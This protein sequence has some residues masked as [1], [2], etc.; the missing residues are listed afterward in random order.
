MHHLHVKTTLSATDAGT[1]AQATNQLEL[2]AVAAGWLLETV[3][4]GITER[5]IKLKSPVTDLEV[6]VVWDSVPTATVGSPDAGVIPSDKLCVS[7]AP[8]GGLVTANLL[9]S[10]SQASLWAGYW[11]FGPVQNQFGQLLTFFSEETVWFFT[12]SSNSY[13]WAVAG[14]VLKADAPEAGQTSLDS[15]GRVPVLGSSVSLAAN[16]S[17]YTLVTAGRALCDDQGAANRPNFRYY[18]YQSATWRA[19]KLRDLYSAFVPL[20]SRDNYI[21][22]DL[23]V[24]DSINGTVV[25]RYRDVHPCSVAFGAP[26]VQASTGTIL[27]YGWGPGSTATQ[28]LLFRG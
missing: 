6:A 27:G 13:H 5:G 11:W 1:L 19:A 20:D 12:E 17:T 3:G 23:A 28:G 14:F 8:A 22:E 16:T 15:T 2:D 18:D 25:G 24:I 21:Q 10:G 7:V 9:N 26:V 4:D